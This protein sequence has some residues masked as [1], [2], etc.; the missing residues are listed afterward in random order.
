MSSEYIFAILKNIDS[1]EAFPKDNLPKN[2]MKNHITV[3]SALYYE[4]I[5]SSN[6]ITNGVDVQNDGFVRKNEK[7]QRFDND[8]ETMMKE[9]SELG[10]SAVRL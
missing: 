5:D 4:N 9:R 8:Y 3:F 6:N 1:T 7:A 10:S 2:I